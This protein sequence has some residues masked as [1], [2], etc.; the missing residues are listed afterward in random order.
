MIEGLRLYGKDI[1]KVV[2]HIGTRSKHSVNMRLHKLKIELKN[3]SELLGADI[4]HIID[5]DFAREAA[6]QS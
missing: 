3:D 1:D 6:I 2:K 4:R 5:S